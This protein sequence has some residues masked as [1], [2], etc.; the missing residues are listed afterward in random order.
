MKKLLLTL[1][2]LLFLKTITYSQ[3]SLSVDEE[4]G[5][6]NLDSAT[7]VKL[8]Y[9]GNNNY[10]HEIYEEHEIEKTEKFQQ[11]Q[12]IM[13]TDFISTQSNQCNEVRLSHTGTNNCS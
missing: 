11:Y 9:F 8:P 10:L 4:C 5:T 7:V 2:C 13:G 12:K 3:D 1:S 6:Q